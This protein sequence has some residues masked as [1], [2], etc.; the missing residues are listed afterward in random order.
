MTGHTAPPSGVRA[1][2]QGPSLAENLR[3]VL[4]DQPPR[5]VEHH[6]VALQ[7]IGTGDKYAIASCGALSTEGAWVWR[8]K[9]SIDRRF[10]A[11]Y[12]VADRTRP[13]LRSSEA[14]R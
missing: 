10:I 12:R 13:V 8:W 4:R 2:R 1:V 14:P 3:L 6:A 9:D 7:L 5:A 11:R